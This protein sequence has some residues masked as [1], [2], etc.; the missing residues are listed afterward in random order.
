MSPSMISQRTAHRSNSVDLSQNQVQAGWRSQSIQ[1]RFE[2]AQLAHASGSGIR[3]LPPRDALSLLVDCRYEEV[4]RGLG[5]ILSGAELRAAAQKLNPSAAART[6]NESLTELTTAKSNKELSPAQLCVARMVHALRVLGLDSA[7]HAGDRAISLVEPY[8]HLLEH[9]LSVELQRSAGTLSHRVVGAA[10][11][12][13]AQAHRDPAAQP[14]GV[15]IV[16]AARERGL[17]CIMV[18]SHHA[19]GGDAVPLV[20]EHCAREGLLNGEISCQRLGLTPQDAHI[21]WFFKQDPLNWQECFHQ[22]GAIAV[23]SSGHLLVV[24]DTLSSLSDD[25]LPFPIEDLIR[26]AHAKCHAL[27]SKPLIIV[28]DKEQAMEALDSLPIAAVATD[29]FV[30]TKLGS[31]DKSCGE[32]TVREV[33]AP[34]LDEDQ[35]NGLLRDAQSVEDEVATVMSQEIAALLLME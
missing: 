22:L 27:S 31:L 10:S 15:Q 19:L 35:I 32:A 5:F 6:F 21:F 2:K 7:T 20:A 28:P 24:Q 4:V 9:G 1:E 13:A 33:L 12:I 3:P 34:F 14:C 8:A 23:H 25:L 29:L 18:S 16:R 30:P 11:L 26:E 17:P